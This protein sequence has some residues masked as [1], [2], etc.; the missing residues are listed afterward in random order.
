MKDFSHYLKGRETMVVMYLNI[1]HE[2]VKH[3]LNILLLTL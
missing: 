2:R 1:K 3:I